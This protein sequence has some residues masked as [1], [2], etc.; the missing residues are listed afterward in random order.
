M[1]ISFNSLVAAAVLTALATPAFAQLSPG[2]D[3]INGPVIAAQTLAS[4]TG[5]VNSGGSITVGASQ[6]AVT[7]TGSSTLVNNGTIQATGTG[8]ALDTNT[9]NLNLTII[10]NGLMSA[11]ASDTFRVNKDEAVSLTNSGTIQ[12]TGGG[13]QAIDWTGIATKASTL[14]NTAT[15][16]ITGFGDDAIRLGVGSKVINHGTISTTPVPTI[17]NCVVTDI[18]GSD[19][20]DVRTFTGI[21]VDNYNTITGRHGIVP[22]PAAFCLLMSA[23]GLLGVFR[24]H[25][26]TVAV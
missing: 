7:I 8:R 24:R 15:G 16:V 5:T 17:T 4:G 3:P 9:N 22:V 23:I 21:Q 2:P 12:Q 20:I 14:L 25:R 6:T 13:Q 18:S 10:N 26:A 11:V 19:G 1:R